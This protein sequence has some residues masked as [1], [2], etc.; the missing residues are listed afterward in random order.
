MVA[1]NCTTPDYDEIYAPWLANPGQLL[2]LCN[3]QPGMTLLDLCGGTGAVSREAIRRGADPDD[4][5]L[6][7][8]SPRA[9]NLGIRQWV[10]SA[11][12]LRHVDLRA[13]FDRVVMRQAVG[14]LD[15]SSLAPTFE[16][17]R[18]HLAPAGKFAFNAFVAPRRFVRVRGQH[19]EAGFAWGRTVWHLQT[20]GLKWDLSRFQWHTGSE[21]HMA[22]IAAGFGLVETNHDSKSLR[23]LC[24]R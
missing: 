1:T 16:G 2:D 10:Y 15:F 6:I 8:L 9:H 11:E 20:V 13:N 14:Y 19:L 7:D 3:W 17:V 22:A 23:F 21:L 4:I 18:R 24:H 5:T 12:M